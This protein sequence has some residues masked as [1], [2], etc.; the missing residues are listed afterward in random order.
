MNELTLLMLQASVVGGAGGVLVWGLGFA[1]PNHM[2]ARVRKRAEEAER[3]AEAKQQALRLAEAKRKRESWDRAKTDAKQSGRWEIVRG[4]CPELVPLMNAPT[5]GE[6]K[7]ALALPA[8][9]K[10][11]EKLLGLD[12]KK[13]MV[14]L[15]DPT[16]DWLADFHENLNRLR[17]L[18]KDD[19]LPRDSHLM[20]NHVFPAWIE[21]LAVA[22]TPGAQFA[23][24]AATLKTEE[25]QR[26]ERESWALVDAFCPLLKPHMD[27]PTVGEVKRAIAL[28]VFQEFRVWLRANAGAWRAPAYTA[29][30]AAETLRAWLEEARSE[31]DDAQLPSESLSQRYIRWAT[32]FQQ[33]L[34]DIAGAIDA[35]APTNSNA[36]NK[37]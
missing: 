19:E 21:E 34:Q 22:A 3:A 28:P 8:A 11:R 4:V 12:L 7:R 9:E 35:P 24:V 14:V 26:L 30:Y 32:V 33:W 27:A 16:A 23:Q 29:G 10:V 25:I 18:G 20:S 1:V 15:M 31:S 37:S 17:A 36:G 6:L 13:R 2:A 5:V